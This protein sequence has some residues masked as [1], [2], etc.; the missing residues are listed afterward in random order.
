MSKQKAYPVVGIIVLFAVG[1]FAIIFGGS[2][3][4]KDLTLKIS[5]VEARGK[6]VSKSRGNISSVR[7]GNKE[8]FFVEY[9]FSI[10][11]KRHIGKMQVSSIAYRTIG[12]GEEVEVIYAWHNPEISSLKKGKAKA[13]IFGPILFVVVGL[14]FV[15]LSLVITV[16]TLKRKKLTNQFKQEK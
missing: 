3:L 4:V 11:D 6:V 5:G 2:F 15:I 8:T 10:G 7:H 13:A 12:E 14:I 16:D 9:K 1:L